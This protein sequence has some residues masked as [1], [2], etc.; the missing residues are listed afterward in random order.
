MPS[1]NLSTP[2]VYLCSKVPP[3]ISNHPISHTSVH[4]FSCL[5]DMNLNIFELISKI[6]INV[7]EAIMDT[8]DLVE[9]PKSDE[10]KLAH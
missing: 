8:K 1:I 9:K 7:Y 4:F 5:K 10:F 6:F 3:V 2:A